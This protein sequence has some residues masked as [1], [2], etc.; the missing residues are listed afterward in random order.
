MQPDGTAASEMK[1][2]SSEESNSRLPASTGSLALAGIFILLTL[3]TLHFAASLF[4]PIYI[5]F[6]MSLA[7]AP[8]VRGL[9]RCRIPR[10]LGAAMVLASLV[11]AGGYTLRTL[12]APAAEW[13]AKAPSS[14]K[15]IER[16]LRFVKKPIEQVTKATE[17]VEDM[18]NVDVEKPPAVQVYQASLAETLLVGTR[19]FLAQM[20]L[21]FVLLYFLLASADDVLCRLAGTLPQGSPARARELAQ[22]VEREISRYLLTNCLINTGLAIVVATTMYL[23]GMP[24]PILWGAVAGALNFMPVVGAICTTGILALISLLTFDNLAHAIMPPLSFV[25]ITSIEGFFVTPA[26]VGRR[27]ALSPIA[28]LLSLLTWSWIWG[29]AGA[30][31]AVPTLAILKIVYDHVARLRRIVALRQP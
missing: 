31:I 15:Q 3:Y 9:H 20:F 29:A 12:S 18:A 21:V 23:L 30:L 17:S 16:R 28:I 24:S 1:R 7:L 14:F 25:C 26:F 19:T 11:A 4:L 6:L 8:F 22:L 2:E 10:S 5:A 13:L 27:L